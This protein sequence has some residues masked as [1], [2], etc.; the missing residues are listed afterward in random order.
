M[1]PG[2]RI[3]ASSRRESAANLTPAD[4]ERPG[5]RAEVV[6]SVTRTMNWLSNFSAFTIALLTAILICNLLI[7]ICKS[8]NHFLRWFVLSLKDPHNLPHFLAFGSTLLLAVFAYLAWTESQ[9]T[10]QALQGQLNAMLAGQRPY[11]GPGSELGV[12]EPRLK[13][14]EIVWHFQF[15][16]YGPGL[17]REIKFHTF[18]KVADGQ[19]EQS[20]GSRNPSTAADMPP[21]PSNFFIRT[22]ALSAPD[23]TLTQDRI[24]KLLKTNFSIQVLAEFE[25]E[26]IYNKKFT[27]AFCLAH[28]ATGAPIGRHPDDCAR[29]KAER[30]A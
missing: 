23:L 22:A 13:E 5:R 4:A 29:E 20:F 30:G 6:F 2:V 27:S 8:I 3:R 21:P 17:A 26:D 19:F 15:R 9:R 14:G 28:I 18:I 16:N 25:Y 11:I 12:P 24:D 7:Y 1:G 10:T